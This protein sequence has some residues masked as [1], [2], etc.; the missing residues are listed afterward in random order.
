M[1]WLTMPA[2]AIGFTLMGSVCG[3]VELIADLVALKNGS[4]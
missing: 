2:R 1:T 4:D 3:D